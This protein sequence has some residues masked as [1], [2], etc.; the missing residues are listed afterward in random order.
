M[1]TKTQKLSYLGLIGIL[2]TYAGAQEHHQTTENTIR[3]NII[4]VF[5]DQMRNSAMGFWNDPPYSSHL[6]GK[7]DPVHTPNLNRFAKESV[8]FSSAMS[9][10]PL[11]SPHRGSLFTG[12][13]PHQSG[14]PLNVNNSRPITSLRDDAVTISDVFSR[15]GY[16]CAYIGKYHLDFPT[17]NDPENPGHYVENRD[18]VWDTY[19]PPE[20]RHGFNFWYSY[21]T[22]DIHKN[23]HY[24]DTKGKRHDIKQWSA[25]HETD[26]AINYLKNQSGERDAS[27]PFLMMI[28]MNP[29]HHPYYSLDDCIKDD[30]ELYKNKSLGELLVRSNV[31]TTMEKASY[32]PYYFAQITGVDREFGRLLDM[33]DTLGLSKNTIVVF[34]SD[35]GETMCSQ[36]LKDAKNS[37]YIEAMNV[38]FLL[39]Y[40]EKLKPQVVDYL[41]SSPDIMPT[42]IGLSN[43]QKHIPDEVQGMDFSETLLTRKAGKPL[44][45]GALYIRNINGEKDENGKIKTYIPAARGI[46]THRYTLS[47]TIDYGSRQLKEV[48]L[49]DDINDPHQKNNIDWDTIPQVKQQLLKQLGG[50]LKKY[51][52]PWYKEGILKDLVVYE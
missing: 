33:L 2:P 16:E 17:P 38:P 48:L 20:K 1:L 51:D 3:P 34:S 39:R 6:Q 43:L 35:H 41:L 45:E 42:L 9:N 47:L 21:G 28:S 13:Y 19:T 49:F 52:D 12:M 15:N 22:F 37:P 8:V 18:P 30:Y 14:V 29:P 7:A 50:L 25:S 24:W 36:G 11:S 23:P 31:D 46:K 27:K 4:Y 44:P 26:I 32:A 10:C 5:P 40:P